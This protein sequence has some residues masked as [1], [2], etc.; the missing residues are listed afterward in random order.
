MGLQEFVSETLKSIIAGVKDA[1]EFAAENDACINPSSF[2]TSKPMH[3]I[4]VGEGDVSIVQPVSFSLCVEETS[5]SNGKLGI[6]VVSGYRE[7]TT[8]ITNRIQFSIAVSL[9][10]MKPN[11][12]ISD[13]EKGV[14]IYGK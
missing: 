11:F 6:Q 13:P 10:R 2:G 14:S 8:S 3:V 1:Q 4:H 5:K 9:P 12:D 7:N